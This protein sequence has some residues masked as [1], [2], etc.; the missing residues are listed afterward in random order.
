[1]SE[2]LELE[3]AQELAPTLAPDDLWERVEIGLAAR[4]APVAVMRRQV[5]RW[6]IAAIV[7]LMVAA[8]TLWLAAK[9]QEPA[10]NLEALAQEELR[11]HA[12]LDLRSS[13][14]AEIT[15]WMREHAD[16]SVS[17]PARSSA[18]LAGVRLIRKG[19]VRVAAVEYTVG[20]ASATLLAARLGPAPATPHGRPS[21]RSGDQGFALACA[22][23]E[24]PEAACLLCHASL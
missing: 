15:A 17:L 6:P 4:R 21:W 12:P 5:P 2:W 1:M 20:G 7:T 11:D 3:I 23:A 10:P 18:H 24:R 14:P 16:V 19:G 22:D 8:A 9:G 13:D